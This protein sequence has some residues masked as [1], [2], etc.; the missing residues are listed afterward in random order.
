MGIRLG[1]RLA[2]GAGGRMPHQ[3]QGGGVIQE[4]RPVAGAK[5]GMRTRSFRVG[6]ATGAVPRV[7]VAVNRALTKPHRCEKSGVNRAV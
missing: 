7:P 6:G 2:L 3:P 1:F 4:H 5:E